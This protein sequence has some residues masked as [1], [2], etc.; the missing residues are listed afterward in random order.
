MTKE[1]AIR[2]YRK[3][4]G[5]NSYI[6]GFL[7]KKKLYYIEMPEIPP[8]FIS[9][10][11]SSSKS[12]GN[13]KLQLSLNNKH[14][15]FL[16]KKGAVWI[17]DE[18]T[19]NQERATTKG[20]AFERLIYRINNQEP[21]KKDCVGFWVCGD[22]NIEGREVQIKF[23]G[24]QIVIFN[25]LKCLQWCGENYKNYTPKRTKGDRKEYCKN[26]KKGVDKPPNL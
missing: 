13:E 17:G 18:T 2:Y 22:I 26:I 20:E 19:L 8:R 7:Y 3:F 5:A 4:S 12:G 6:I 10:Q 14:K 15:E 1:N 11:K 24:A 16:I 25:T 23:Q 9:V 21:R